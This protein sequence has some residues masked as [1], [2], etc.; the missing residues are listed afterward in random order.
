[1]F[2]RIRAKHFKS[3][4]DTGEIRFAPITAFFGPNSS[5]KTSLLQL[6]L[7]L[8][9]TAESADRG[10]VLSFGDDP[11]SLVDL[12]DFVSLVH[13]HNTDSRLSWTLEW[14]LLEEL[15]IPDPFDPNATFLKADR[16]SFDA[17]VGIQQ[18]VGSPSTVFAVDKLTYGFAGS[19]FSMQ[20]RAGQRPGYELNA[21][22]DRE[23][24]FIRSK[25]RAWDLPDPVK[26]YGFPDQVRGYFQN[27]GFLSDFEFQFE[28][29]FSRVYYLG[30]L[31]AYPERQYTWAGAQPADM[32]QAGEQAV[33]ALLASRDR[34]ETI[35]QGRG[36][37]RL[38]LEEYV[39]SWLQELGLIH[40]FSVKKLSPDSKVFEVHVKKSASSA[41]V[42][43]TDVGFGVSQILPVIVLSFYV[44]EGS[45]VIFEQPEIHLHPSVQAGLADVLIDAV[46]KKN[47]QIV[48]ESH[49]EHLLRRLQRRVAEDEVKPEQLAL[50]FCDHDG[51]QSKLQ[52]LKLDTEGTIANWPQNFFGDE[53]GEIA[54][55]TSAALKKKMATP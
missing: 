13:E 8:K 37:K 36:I 12:S 24:R 21:Q 55:T 32:G 20:R 39:A 7:M 14:S 43:I 38:T 6:L 18:T 1:M 33:A 11:K 27:A 46:Q 16:M 30:P 9:Q 47:I 2:T 53:F 40:S 3:W 50:Y 5:G 41:D 34:G 25:G 4:K 19:Q 22:T 26:C 42:L 52:P 45:T 48:L 29:L 31:R 17:S 54:A 28:R 51:I 49:S 15:K 44:P 23:F 10:L 35:S